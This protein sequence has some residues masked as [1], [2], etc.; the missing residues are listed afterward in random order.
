[1]PVNLAYNSYRLF[2]EALD[3]IYPPACGGCN[4]LGVRWCNDC[5]Q[6][7][8]EV[9]PPLCPVCGNQNKNNDICERC[10]DSRPYYHC[11]K[12]YTEYKG[13]IR[14]AVHRFKYGRDMAL[15]EALSRL[16]I[17]RIEKLNWSLDVVTSVPLGLVRFKERGYNQATL[18]ARPIALWLRKPFKGR[19]LMRARVTR[20][21]VGL[22]AVQRRENMIDAF[23]ANSKYVA[24]KKVLLIDDVATSGATLNACAKALLDGGADQVYCFTLARAIFQPGGEVDDL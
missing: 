20:S 17:N 8:I 6:A 7:T 22:T 16:M 5:A 18:L 1:M 11:L 21:Q 10:Q 14:E 12:S 3:W 19:A 4:H 13:K 15:G 24:G 23:L 9:Q 2:W